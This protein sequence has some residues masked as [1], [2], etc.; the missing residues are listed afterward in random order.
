MAN[1][2]FGKLEQRND[3]CRT[4]F[5]NKFADIEEMYFSENTIQ[6]LFCINA[7]ICQIQ[8]SPNIY[9]LPPNRNNNCYIGA[10]VTA[11]AR[12]T[13]YCHLVTLLEA[14]AHIY[15][16][17]CDSIIFSLKN[18]NKMPLQVSEVVGHFK[19]E[20]PGNILSFYS[21]GPK[22]YTITYE[23]QDTKEILTMSRI[24]GLSLNNS[25]NN[26]SFNESL[27]KSYV[28]NFL[29][30]KPQITNVKQ[31]RK[32]GNFKKLKL[33]SQLENVTFSNS[34]S[35]RRIIEPTS[36]NLTS[37]PYGYADSNKVQ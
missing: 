37:Y 3:K 16:I 7:D 5:A 25:L 24:R 1:A 27:F 29:K 28:T 33:S 14:K 35:E 32:R 31:F 9:K 15:Q 13:I 17:D 18:D 2:L 10:Q 34:L 23:N 30:Q 19:S 26:V 8:I 36:L 11:Y 12:Q 6:D 4:I 20:I 21:L 22:N